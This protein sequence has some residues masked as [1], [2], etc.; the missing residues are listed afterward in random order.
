[1]KAFSPQ[2]LQSGPELRKE[3]KRATQIHQVGGG[4]VGFW[5]QPKLLEVLFSERPELSLQL[6]RSLQKGI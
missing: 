5:D 2:D 3:I 6:V 1:M 4:R